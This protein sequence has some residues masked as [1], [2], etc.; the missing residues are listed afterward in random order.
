MG[1]IKSKISFSALKNWWNFTNMKKLQ[2][3]L[4]TT[5]K[6]VHWIN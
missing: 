2:I 3:N 1:L 4:I 6:G 5:Q